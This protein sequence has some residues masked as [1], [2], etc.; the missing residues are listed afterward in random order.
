MRGIK[1]DVT[2]TSKEK[3][4]V[5]AVALKFLAYLRFSPGPVHTACFLS[6]SVID[7]HQQ[8]ECFIRT[9]LRL[10]ILENPVY[11]TLMIF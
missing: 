3:Q 6:A 9:L 4:S 2:G 7:I 11:A 1:G 8:Q 5:R 10:L